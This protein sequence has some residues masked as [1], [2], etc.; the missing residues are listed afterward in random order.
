MNITIDGLE[1]FAAPDDTIMQ[2]AKRAD[3]FIPGLC[4][5]DAVSGNNCC[6]LCMV[7]IEERGRQKLVAACGFKAKEGL[8]VTTKTERVDRI[9]KTVLKL[10]Y[11][12]APENPTLLELMK[13]YDVAAESR[14]PSKEGQCILCGLCVDACKAL[15]SSSISTISRG[16][17][18]KVST[19]YGEASDSCIG[20]GSCVSVCPTKCIEVIDDDAGRTIWNKKFEWARCEKCGVIVTTKEHYL[21]SNGPDLPVI[22]PAC[23]RHAITD[24][25]ADTLGE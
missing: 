3:T 17:T 9:R 25:F 13:K 19:P 23:K 24:V 4:H 7:E 20:C 14:L 11:S 18:K 10:M 21:A 16:I 22:C 15:G 8:I 5:G 12:Q 2:A 6:R 1:I